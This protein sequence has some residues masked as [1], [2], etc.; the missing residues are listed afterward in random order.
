MK[1]PIFFQDLQ[2]QTTSTNKEKVLKQRS[3]ELLKITSQLQMEP[4]LSTPIEKME[5]YQL[6]IS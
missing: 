1:K 4:Q 5:Y 3:S 6:M 2:K